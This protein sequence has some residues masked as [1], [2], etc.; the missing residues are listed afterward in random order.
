MVDYVKTFSCPNCSIVASG[1]GHLCHPSLENL[2]FDCEHCGKS[3][4]DPR[5][6]CQKMIDKVE[7]ACKKC[8]RVALY[9]SRLCE[10]VNLTEE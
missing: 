6:F 2:P 8:G 3:V 10:P 5:H 1:R 7:Y 9:S 4:D